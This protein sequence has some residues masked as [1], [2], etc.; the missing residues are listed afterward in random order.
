M[1]L[2]SNQMVRMHRGANE[3]NSTRYNR[4][5]QDKANVLTTGIKSTSCKVALL[6]SCP[7]NE[8]DALVALISGL[9]FVAIILSIPLD[10]GRYQIESLYTRTQEPKLDRMN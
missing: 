2:T 3:R 10:D 8:S 4:H 7:F 1:P 9:T 5:S 6:G